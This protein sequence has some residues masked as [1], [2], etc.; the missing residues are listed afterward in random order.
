M[1]GA[2][3]GSV[4]AHRVGD[5]PVRDR[6]HRAVVRRHRLRPAAACRRRAAASRMVPARPRDGARQRRQGGLLGARIAARHRG[7]RRTLV[8][9]AESGNDGGAVG[10]RHGLGDRYRRLFCRTRLWRRAA[11]ADDQPFENLVGARRRHDRGADCQRDDRR[12]RPDYR[13]PAVDRPVH[14]PPRAA[15]RPWR[16]LDETPRRGQGSRAS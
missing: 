8:Y 3:V 4:G 11:R 5:H 12:P 9:P 2:A 6:R 13:R 16:K 1:A 10:V 15:R 14:G 7:D